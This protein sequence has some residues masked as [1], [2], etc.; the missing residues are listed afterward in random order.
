MTMTN[1]E[2]KESLDKEIV[3][4]REA[5]VGDV[6]KFQDNLCYIA[7]MGKKTILRLFDKESKEIR[8]YQFKTV[9]RL[10]DVIVDGESMLSEELSKDY[11]KMFTKLKKGDFVSFMENDKRE[12]GTVLK[13][14]KKPTVLLKNGLQE[15]TAS[16][17]LFDKEDTPKPV[18]IPV[19]L[20]DWSC[21]SYKENKLMS[22]ETIAFS[23]YVKNKNKK[24]FT[25][26]NAGHGGCMDVRHATKENPYE[27][28]N[29]FEALIKK[30]ILELFPD[31]NERPA[32]Y[33]V[34]EDY[35]LWYNQGRKLNIT[36]YQH[37]KS[38]MEMFES[39]K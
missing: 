18:E 23:T 32:M 30:S 8:L 2:I 25:A 3:L 37:L 34:V 33:D 17:M 38:S 13:G 22:E 11:K 19:L 26:S 1:K 7:E 35:V 15:I 39:F 12:Y 9:P 27:Y 28:H 21:V 36:W 4:K 6:V 14:G 16:H 10:Y 20:K 24:V 29:E 31:E 5:K